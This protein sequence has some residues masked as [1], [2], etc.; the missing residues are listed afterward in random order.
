MAA[1]KQRVGVAGGG[2][3]GALLVSAGERLGIEVHVLDPVEQAP[4]REGA[5]RFVQGRWDDPAALARLAEGVDVLTVERDD[6]SATCWETLRE[7][8][9]RVEPSPEALRVIQD[10]LAQREH[11]AARGLPVPRFAACDSPCVAALEEFGFP[12]VQKV[13]RGG[14]DGQGVRLH[15]EA[16]IE[17]LP[18]PSLL[19]EQVPIARELTVLVARS[20]QGEH[21]VYPVC[22]VDVREQRLD[23]L[24]QPAR[25]TPEQS[26]AAQELALAALEGLAGAGIAAVELFL[27]EAGELLI[28]EVS[29]RPHNSGHVT[30]DANET[31]QFEQHLRAVCGAPLG[32]AAATAPAAALANI[33]GSGAE[34]GPARWE[35]V[36]AVEALEGVSLHRYAKAEVWPGRKMGH[37]TVCGDDWEQVRARAR[38]VQRRITVAAA[39]REEES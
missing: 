30:L 17:P 35:G 28:N 4:A 31:D 11:H 14:Y 23:L 7:A 2:Q 6:V 18:A 39:R 33:V 34:R 13:R 19:E 36:A 21:V 27:T 24:T 25:L 26:A 12:L 9:A 15:P 20:R 37:L 32:S 22:E 10:K 5:A 8:G 16:G 1:N 3:L 38:E 29:L